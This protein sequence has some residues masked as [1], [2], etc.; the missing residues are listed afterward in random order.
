M[1]LDGKEP[2]VE[3]LKVY[4][5]QG[6][7]RATTVLAATRGE[8]LAI[9]RT[10]VSAGD[11]GAPLDS[12]ALLLQE[13]DDTGRL[14]ASSIYNVDD[15]DRALAELDERFAS[16][17]DLDLRAAVFDGGLRYLDVVN[18]T[19]NMDD[20]REVMSPEFVLFDHRSGPSL[21]EL[22]GPDAWIDAVKTLEEIAPGLML[23]VLALPRFTTGGI[24]AQLAVAGTTV[25]GSP[26]ELM[27]IVAGTVR[28]GK[29][30][31]AELYDWN[32]LDRA[33]ARFEELTD[34]EAYRLAET[35]C[36]RRGVE[37]GK[38]FAAGDWTALAALLSEN[39]AMQDKRDAVHAE[40]IGRG[41][42]VEMLRT[43]ARHGSKRG[44]TSAVATR[45]E[46]LALLRAATWI[47][48][49]D[50]SA[51]N[52][53]L[54][55]HELNDR[56]EFSATVVYEADQ[57]DEALDDLDER[58]IA[59]LDPEE[60][61]TIRLALRFVES[62]NDVDYARASDLFAEDFILRDLQ[63]GG[64]SLGDVHGATEY[65]HAL[66]AL[67]ELIPNLKLRAVAIPKLATDR[68]VAQVTMEGNTPDG[69]FVE[70]A[71]NIVGCARSG[72]IKS[73]EAY[74]WNEL[75]R[76]IARFN[77]LGAERLVTAPHA[78]VENFASRT[79]GAL[80]LPSTKETSMR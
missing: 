29:A 46:R 3:W 9:I 31:R 63:Y 30:L 72:K 38:Y 66:E 17:L 67:A 16:R 25:D 68:M 44:Q 52:E 36:T 62:F 43:G 56:G 24:V 57:L 79:Y 4:A 26:I 69:A 37:F 73:A 74:A 40:Q 5:E 70:Y 50:P 1:R 28:D 8:H 80:P 54:V 34:T 7:D 75:D 64:A 13:I 55:L 65:V 19:R 51:A 77:E 41:P 60:Q 18:T 15:F 14:V 76:A 45:G 32:E 22:R 33:I 58:F 61:V 2:S 35:A 11:T 71:Y 12:D 78:A 59:L 21:G 49:N 53:C 6:G 39:H 27:Y 42:M 47:G 20:I 10:V 48:L 23:R